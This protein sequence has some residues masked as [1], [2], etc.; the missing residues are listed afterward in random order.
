MTSLNPMSSGGYALGPR[1]G[2]FPFRGGQRRGPGASGAPHSRPGIGWLFITSWVFGSGVS[3]FGFCFKTE[4]IHLVSILYSVT[5][6]IMFLY[7][8]HIG[9]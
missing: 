1:S 2:I 9:C 3:Y 7:W 4:R 6:L 8:L 5:C